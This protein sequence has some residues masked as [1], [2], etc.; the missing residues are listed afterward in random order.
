VD[1]LK[2][3]LD[4]ACKRDVIAPENVCYNLKLEGL[5]VE[6]L[7][8]LKPI[9]NSDYVLIIS[10]DTS[11]VG[12]DENGELCSRTGETLVKLNL[13]PSEL[14]KIH[15]KVVAFTPNSKNEQPSTVVV[16]LA[17]LLQVIRMGTLDFFFS[18]F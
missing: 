5:Q 11:Q 18:A 7:A 8:E 10:A 13:K 9:I 17:E 15:F 2:A 16:S 14:P 6:R 1:K 4:E 3:L 12:I